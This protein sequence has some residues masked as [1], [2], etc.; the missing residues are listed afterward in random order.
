MLSANG[1][2]MPRHRRPQSFR[3]PERGMEISN[4]GNRGTIIIPE[5]I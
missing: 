4:G 5:D 3:K 1:Y 2:V